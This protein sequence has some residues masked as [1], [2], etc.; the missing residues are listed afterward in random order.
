MVKVGDAVVFVD[1]VAHPRPCLVTAVWWRR[2]YGEGRPP[3]GEIDQSFR[4]GINGVLVSD[5]P[6]REDSYGRQIE[7]VTSIA[8]QSNQPAHGNYWRRAD[9]PTPLTP[10]QPGTA[11]AGVAH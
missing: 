5:D 3:E 7:R 6:A 8:H 2:T 4:P 1:L 10:Y 9:D 11:D